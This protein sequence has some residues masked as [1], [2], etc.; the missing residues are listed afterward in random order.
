[1]PLLRGV[2]DQQGTFI[3]V[4]FHDAETDEFPIA[5][6]AAAFDMHAVVAVFPVAQTHALAAIPLFNLENSVDRLSPQVSYYGH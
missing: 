5:L 4:R 1:L 6:A 3:E 2:G